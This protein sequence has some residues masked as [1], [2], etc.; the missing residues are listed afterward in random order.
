[1]AP[2][3]QAPICTALPRSTSR[4]KP[5][6][7][8]NASEISPL[9]MRPTHLIIGETRDE[10]AIDLI[11]ALNSGI[12]GSLSTVHATTAESALVTLTNLVRQAPNPPTEEPAR[13]MVAKAVHVL[14]QIAQ[15]ED[16][17][18]RVMA[19]DEV[20]DV[21]EEHNFDFR[22]RNVFST[23]VVRGGRDKRLFEVRFNVNPDYAMTPFMREKFGRA[24]LDPKDYEGGGQR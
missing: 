12:T 8:S 16:G 10:T 1:M 21:D 13:R 6:G 2:S 22:V 14:V 4:A 24:G 18:R 20:D 7:I 11:R 23:E 3:I 9:R 15:L 5:G 19:I 17:S